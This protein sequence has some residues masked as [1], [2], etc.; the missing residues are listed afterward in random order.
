[1]LK[2]LKNKKGFTLVELIIVIAILAIIMMIAVANYSG[3]K[4]VIQVS[5][6][7]IAAGN[8]GKAVRTWYTLYNMDNAFQTKVNDKADDEGA[9]TALLPTAG[10]PMIKLDQLLE[11]DKHIDPATSPKSLRDASGKE[12][13]ATAQ[14]FYVGT[15]GNGA[16]EKVV[17]CIADDTP[18]T[19]PASATKEDVLYDGNENNLIDS[20]TETDTNHLAANYFNY[21]LAYLES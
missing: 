2:Q 18:P 14:F 5:S 12:V 6:D 21:S 8:V 11:I 16:S 3:I 4:Q 7:K 13:A 9:T 15:V 19:L 10:N 1:M 20:G 17:V